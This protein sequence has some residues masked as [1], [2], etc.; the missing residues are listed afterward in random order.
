MLRGERQRGRRSATSSRGSRSSSRSARTGGPSCTGASLA[1]L[2]AS[3]RRACSPDP[4]QLAHHADAA[5]DAEAV[6]ALRDRGR[7]AGGLAGRASR[8]GRAVRARRALRGQPG[9]L[10]SCAELLERLAP[11]SATSRI[12]ST[13]AAAAQERALECY[14]ELGD[15]RSEAVA[16]CALSEMIWCGGYIAESESAGREAVG[17]ARR[18]RAGTGA[19]TRIPQPRHALGEPRDGDRMGVAR[20]H[21][22]RA[23]RRPSDRVARP[24]RDG[25][26]ALSRQRRRR[27]APPARGVAGARRCGRV[28]AGS[29]LDLV[30]AR[31]GRAASPRLRRRRPLRR[32]RAGA[33]R[34]V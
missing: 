25:C 16:L 7:R 1:A 32:G 28:R 13:T 2:E 23:P 9:A 19:R 12:R 26:R 5:G 20:R 10:P 21:A 29:R 30:P 11:A 34:A 17:G 31:A 24:H 22:R 8:G 27:G 3:A 4:A 6:S 33:L 14:R 15:R 18:P